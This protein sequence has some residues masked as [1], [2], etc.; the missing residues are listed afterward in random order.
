[1]SLKKEILELLLEENMFGE[2]LYISRENL[3]NKFGA[4]EVH[5]A[6]IDLVDK[7]YVAISGYGSSNVHITAAGLESLK[8]ECKLRDK[9]MVWKTEKGDL[10][11]LTHMSDE[12]L[13][14][15]ILWLLTGTDIND[16]TEGI[17]ITQWVQ[18]MAIELNNRMSS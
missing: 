6:L 4:G 16:K 3:E 10:V 18:A 11:R 1:M 14:N 17:P 9:P 13:R 15:A 5:K 8:D 7:G 12:H 2:E